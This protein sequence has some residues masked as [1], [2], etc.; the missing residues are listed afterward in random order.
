MQETFDAFSEELSNAQSLI[1]TAYRNLVLGSADIASNVQEVFRA[2]HTLASSSAMVGLSKTSDL[3]KALEQLTAQ[4]S[5]VHY[6]PAFHGLLNEVLIYLNSLL[7]NIKQKKLEESD[8]ALEILAGTRFLQR[9][10]GKVA[11]KYRIHVMFE[12]S[13]ELKNIRAFMVL[14]ELREHV[15]FV[16]LNPD[17]T[18]NQNANLNNG[19]ELEV[20]SNRDAKT[21]H[22]IISGVL[23][24]V[25]VKIMIEMRK[26]PATYYIGGYA[27]SDQDMRVTEFVT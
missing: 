9:I 11:R 6:L 10:G 17:L 8:D 26:S 21:L 4:P 13:Y 22:D 12:E 1:Y 18:K 19:M 24:V 14:K 16:S 15:Q 20:V 5:S 23:E 3:M 7:E 2:A 27:L 25:G